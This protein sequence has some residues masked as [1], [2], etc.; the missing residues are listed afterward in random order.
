M[1]ILIYD[2][3]YPAFLKDWWKENLPIEP[4]LS[5]EDVHS[6]L[7]KSRFGLSDSYS[8]FFKAVGIDAIDLVLN[9]EVS[10]KKWSQEHKGCFLDL[11]DVFLSQVKAYKPKIIFLQ[12]IYAFPQSF[13]QQIKADFGCEIWGQHASRL[14][15]GSL[16]HFD[17]L[18]SSLKWQVDH[19]RKLGVRS[20]YLPLGFDVRVL[21]ELEA[22]GGNHTSLNCGLAFGSFTRE[23]YQRIDLLQNLKKQGFALNVRG[24]CDEE[25]RQVY[26][27]FARELGAPVFGLE[28][29]RQIRKHSF[30]L[31]SHSDESRGE[32]NN[33]RM[34]EVTGV[35]SA[36]ITNY[37]DDLK[38]KFRSN[39]VLAY[40]SQDDLMQGIDQILQ[41][42]VYS[43]NLG[44]L[45]QQ[46][47]LTTHVYT[48][49]LI[50]LLDHVRTSE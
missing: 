42:Q 32:S 11:A 45:G 14:Y 30:V 1:D 48:K 29:F 2:T 10:Q 21:W 18:Y 4:D 43:K 12:N 15:S 36:L 16:D 22:L 17:R 34:Y 24:I 9:D 20:S 6:C 13:I 26:P 3:Y 35:G 50:R 33:M 23:H 40:H 44:C 8:S 28:L 38:E 37:T 47:T 25:V 7:M 39:E 41:N 46:R 19:F 31:N 49:N 27:E 5:F